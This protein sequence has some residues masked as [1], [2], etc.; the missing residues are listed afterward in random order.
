MI[1]PGNSSE[2]RTIREIA[3]TFICLLDSCLALHPAMGA[4]WRRPYHASS[5]RERSLVVDIL[6]KCRGVKCSEHMPRHAFLV[7]FEDSSEFCPYSFVLSHRERERAPFLPSRGSH[8]SLDLR[9]RMRELRYEIE[10]KTQSPD[11]E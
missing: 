1:P 9:K 3:P 2:R 11:I 7:S 4:C 10:S 6:A 8:D 5:E